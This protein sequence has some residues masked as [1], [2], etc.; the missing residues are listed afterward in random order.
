MIVPRQS[1]SFLFLIQ[2]AYLYILSFFC[3][4]FQK[5]SIDLSTLEI[6]FLFFINEFREGASTHQGVLTKS[7][8]FPPLQLS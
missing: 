5:F 8:G 2:T 7:L 1:H 6:Y 4:F 3:C